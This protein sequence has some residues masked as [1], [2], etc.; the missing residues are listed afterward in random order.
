MLVNLTGGE[1]NSNKKVCSP[2]I[3]IPPQEIPA[4]VEHKDSLPS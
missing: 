4:F 3:N 1:W 2:V